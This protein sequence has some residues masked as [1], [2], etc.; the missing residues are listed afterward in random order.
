MTSKLGDP[1]YLLPYFIKLFF[2]RAIFFLHLDYSKSIKFVNSARLFQY[3]KIKKEGREKE[4][5]GEILCISQ[6]RSQFLFLFH[7]PKLWPLLMHQLN[8]HFLA[9]LGRAG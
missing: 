1:L 9:V 2:Q 5:R 4:I 7:D 6:G 3:F 8:S